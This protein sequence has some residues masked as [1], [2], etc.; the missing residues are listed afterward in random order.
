MDDPAGRLHPLVAEAAAQVASCAVRLE[1][2]AN[3]A[4]PYGSD[5]LPEELQQR[6]ADADKDLEHRR[7]MLRRLREKLDEELESTP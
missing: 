7:G 6:L 1:Y 5:P 2:W 4:R 3:M